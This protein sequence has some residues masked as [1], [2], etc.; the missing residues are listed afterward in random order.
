MESRAA[1]FFFSF[2]RVTSCEYTRTPDGQH[3]YLIAR[4]LIGGRP[5]SCGRVGECMCAWKA[6]V[7]CERTV[8]DASSI[9]LLSNVT[10]TLCFCI[11]SL[12][13]ALCSILRTSTHRAGHTCV[14]GDVGTH[15]ERRSQYPNCSKSASASPTALMCAGLLARARVPRH[16]KAV[17]A[18]TASQ[19]HIAN[20]AAAASRRCCRPPGLFV[21]AQRS[22]SQT[23]APA[24]REARVQHRSMCLASEP[25][26]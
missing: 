10:F 3:P 1:V 23:L 4:P 12:C 11:V 25:S 9:I 15:S 20:V 6:A 16:A 5:L 8:H 21:V 24:P 22:R 19:L 13:L 26:V 17:E 14:S 18:D 2:P 7:R